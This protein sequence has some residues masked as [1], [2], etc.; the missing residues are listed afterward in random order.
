MVVESLQ[1]D[2]PSDANLG[3]FKEA[4][5]I[6]Q[7]SLDMKE[8]YWTEK[9]NFKCLLREDSNSKNFYEVVK[10]RR[11]AKIFSIE[12]Q[13]TIISNYRRPKSICDKLLPITSIR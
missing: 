12:D 9:A 7:T 1:N 13:G 4:T 3:D 10:R 8:C 11:K 2:S 6:F 5:T